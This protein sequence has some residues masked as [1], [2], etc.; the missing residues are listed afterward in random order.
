MHYLA[1]WGLHRR[2]G[3]GYID[4][5]WARRGEGLIPIFTAPPPSR[6]TSSMAPS[7]YLTVLRGS[8]PCR[9]TTSMFRTGGIHAFSNQS[10]AP[11]AMLILFAPEAP[12]EAYF[13]GLNQ[14]GEMV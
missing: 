14:L 10:G 6:F 12:R 11:A 7:A 1:N 9:A 13:E 8:T 2:S 4:G 5:Q 3:S